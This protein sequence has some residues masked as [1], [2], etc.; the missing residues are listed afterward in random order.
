MSRGC[1]DGSCTV[2]VMLKGVTPR[3]LGGGGGGGGD[4]DGGGG[5][6]GDGGDGDGGLIFVGTCSVGCRK[7]IRRGTS[8]L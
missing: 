5:G 7:H 8:V 6:D 1:S 4:G 2:L 3:S